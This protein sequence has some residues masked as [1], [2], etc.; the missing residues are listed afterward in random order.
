[1]TYSQDNEDVILYLMLHDVKKGHYVD[2]GAND[3]E[4]LSVTKLFY[5]MGWNGI[6]IEPLPDVFKKLDDQ[7]PRDINLNIAV[8]SEDSRKTLYIDGMCSSINPMQ[9][10]PTID[11]IVKTLKYIN[12]VFIPEF[13]EDIHF[14]KIDVEGY[15][16][17]VLLGND[18]GAF[19]PWIFCIESTLPS[20]TIPCWDKWEDILI[21][22]DYE[23]VHEH[24][25]NRYYHDKRRN[26]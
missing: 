8:G 13:W 3:P 21:A 6:N 11:V 25:I 26:V 7:R 24:G 5:D 12:Q 4:D 22:N 19:R 23:F 10:R 20:T 2:I 1:M 16:R 17:E 15:E 18:W 9:G 14:C